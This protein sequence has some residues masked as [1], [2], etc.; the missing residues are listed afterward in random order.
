MTE[1][2]SP[3]RGLEKHEWA[4]R[5]RELIE[6]HPL[7][8]REI[9]EVVLGSW[10]SIFKSRI[11]VSGFTIG[12]HIF[13]KP[14]TMGTLLEQ[15]IALEFESRYPGI[16]HGERTAEDKDLVYIPDTRFSVEIKTSS[17]AKNIYGNRSY[18]QVSQTGKKSKSGFYI[19]VNFEK[20]SKTGT[21]LVENTS[22]L[23]EEAAEGFALPRIRLIRF[24]W[25]D[26]T[27]W[28]GQAAATGQ[29]A[30]LDPYIEQAK[31]LR[32]YPSK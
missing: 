25:L 32:L 19:A 17:S 26:H 10:D 20:F 30:R 12:K 8:T 4:E 29:Q 13:L 16:W 6:A 5:T 23:T 7:D 24:G 15:L 3:Y 28:I 27:D 21:P 1:T 18:A 11:G 22:L 9:V 14:Q 31:L 2:L